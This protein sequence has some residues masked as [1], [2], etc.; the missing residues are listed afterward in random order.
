MVKLLK[1]LIGPFTTTRP[2]NFRDIV[3]DLLGGRVGKVAFRYEPGQEMRDK[4]LTGSGAL[5]RK[6]T[7]AEQRI[8]VRQP[9]YTLVD[10]ATGATLGLFHQDSI[11]LYNPEPVS[12]PVKIQ[13]RHRV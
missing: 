10:A 2:S 4:V 7:I 12:N 9:Y 11:E 13:P 5:D 1:I 6:Y 8:Y 3:L